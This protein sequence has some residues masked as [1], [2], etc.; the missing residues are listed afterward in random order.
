MY[1]VGVTYKNELTG[2]YCAGFTTII[3]PFVYYSQFGRA[4]AMSLLFFALALVYYIRLKDGDNHAETRILFWILA[5][6]NVWVHLFAA[7]PIGLMCIDLL[8]DKRKWLCGI[9]AGICSLPLVGMIVNTIA[10]RTHGAYNYGASMIQMAVLTFPEFF[11][12]VFLN[13]LLLAAVGAWLHRDKI[14][15]ILMIITILTLIVGIFSAAITP[16]FPRYM[17]TTSIII[18]L[19]SASGLVALTELLNKKV[20]WDLTYVVMIGVFI[21]FSWMLFPNLESHYFIQQYV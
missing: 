6:L 8:L 2:I 21:V 1:W 16:M 9:G 17:M 20:R 12:T 7:I 4:Y 11:N 10:T 13:V 14:N 5:V 19:F 15:K 3:L 18:L